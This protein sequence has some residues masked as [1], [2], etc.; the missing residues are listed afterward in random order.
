MLPDDDDGGGQLDDGVQAEAGQGDG[1]SDDPCDDRRGGF[2]DHPRD[3]GVSQPEPA[4]PQPAVP[5]T[6][7]DHQA[8]GNTTP[9]GVR[10]C[11]H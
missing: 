10:A 1:G 9:A 3:A 6:I 11:L 8:A 2:D 5:M 4:P 7:A